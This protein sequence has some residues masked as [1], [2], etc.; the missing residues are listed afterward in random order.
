[1]KLKSDSLKD[2]DQQIFEFISDLLE[3]DYTPPAI[4]IGLVSHAAGLGLQSEPDAQKVV[5]NLFLP[6]VHQLLDKSTYED[7]SEDTDDE[8]ITHK[9]AV[10]Q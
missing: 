7:C 10:L 4:C 6:I 9:C 8:R 2:L 1:M 5:G 3:N